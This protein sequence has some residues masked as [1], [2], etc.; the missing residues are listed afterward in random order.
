M[1]TTQSDHDINKEIDSD[2]RM[3]SYQYSVLLKYF[4]NSMADPCVDRSL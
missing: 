2:R 4:Q 3:Q 1:Y